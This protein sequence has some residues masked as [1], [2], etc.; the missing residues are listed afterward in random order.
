MAMNKSK[1]GDK[2]KSFDELLLEQCPYHPHHND[3]ITDVSNPE[4]M[5]LS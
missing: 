1:K 5:V 3:S 4:I 2:N